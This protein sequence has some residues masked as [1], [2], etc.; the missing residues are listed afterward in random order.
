MIEIKMLK[1]ILYCIGGTILIISMFIWLTIYKSI[2]PIER[3]KNAIALE[4]S[5]IPEELSLHLTR[6]FDVF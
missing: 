5:E 6:A 2:V 3:Q 4:S 1:R